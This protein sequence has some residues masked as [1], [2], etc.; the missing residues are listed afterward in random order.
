MCFGGSKIKYLVDGAKDGLEDE[1]PSDVEGVLRVCM[2]K[3][4]DGDPVSSSCDSRRKRLGC[5]GERL[6]EGEDG[7]QHNEVG[8]KRGV[9]VPR[10]RLVACP[11]IEH[12]SCHP[13]HHQLRHHEKLMYQVRKSCVARGGGEG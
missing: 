6:N 9:V 3:A 1:D 11:I 8:P 2:N 5:M 13:H 12:I 4:T 10:S 7:A